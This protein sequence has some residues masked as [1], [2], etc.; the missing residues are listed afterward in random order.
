MKYPL[1]KDVEQFYGKAGSNLVSLELPYT[2]KLAWDTKKNVTRFACH[3]KVKDDLHSIFKDTL[4]HYGKDRIEEL[5]LDLFGGCYNKRKIRGGKNL[6]MHSWGIAVDLNPAEN[7]YR[8]GKD[9]AVFAKS[10]YKP[11]WDIV[12]NY[13]AISLG[14]ERN[15]DFMHFQ[16]ARLK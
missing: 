13:G 14:I 4:E 15:F 12:Y 16:F 6:S 2:M 9:K 8:W 3:S 10:E 1:Q 7:A 11:F 5:G